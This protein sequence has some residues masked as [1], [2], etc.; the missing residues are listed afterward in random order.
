MIAR[1]TREMGDLWS[2]REVRR[3]STSRS[4]VRSAVKLGIVPGGVKV[5]RKKAVRSARVEGSNG[6]R[7]TM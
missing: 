2:E 3:G 6:K 4:G 5:I 1:Y 7:N